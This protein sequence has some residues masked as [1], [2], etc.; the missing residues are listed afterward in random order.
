M[1]LHESATEDSW[2]RLFR[3]ENLMETS[4]FQPHLA[5]DSARIFKNLPEHLRG[6][7]PHLHDSARIRCGFGLNLCEFAKTCK[8]KPHFRTETKR[9]HPFR[10]K[11]ATDSERICMN[12]HESV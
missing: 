8:W 11:P 2:K 12:L 1:N 3:N 9:E 4:R 10:P 7:D 6:F 5:A